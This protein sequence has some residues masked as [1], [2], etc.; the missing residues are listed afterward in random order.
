MNCLNTFARKKFTISFLFVHS[1]Y[2]CVWIKHVVYWPKTTATTTSTK[3]ETN[4]LKWVV[5]L[6]TRYCSSAVEIVYRLR[7]VGCIW[8]VFLMLWRSLWLRIGLGGG[9]LR[10]RRKKK[11]RVSIMSLVQMNEVSL[12]YLR[13]PSWSTHKKRFWLCSSFNCDDR[14]TNTRIT[15]WH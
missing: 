12:F 15:N 8:S 2:C 5:Y 7:C 9:V 11:N 13:S 6:V 3:H 14:L 10:R 1:L 4:E